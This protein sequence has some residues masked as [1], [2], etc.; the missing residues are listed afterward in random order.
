MAGRTSAQW[1]EMLAVNEGCS[2]GFRVDTDQERQGAD[3]FGAASGAKSTGLP[4]G[5]RAGCG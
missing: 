4:G 1:I 3:R 5:G 2:G